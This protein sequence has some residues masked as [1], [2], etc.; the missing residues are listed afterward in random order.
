M[1]PRCFLR[2]PRSGLPNGCL[3]PP[4][5]LYT[6]GFTKKRYHFGCSERAEGESSKPGKK[7]G[8]KSIGAR[9]IIESDEENEDEDSDGELAEEGGLDGESSR[10]TSGRKRKTVDYGGLDQ[11][12]DVGIGDSSSESGGEAIDYSHP[13]ADEGATNSAMSGDDGAISIDDSEP[14]E[15]LAKKKPPAPKRMS[16]ESAAKG[17]SKASQ[18]AAPSKKVRVTKK[19]AADSDSEDNL[20]SEGDEGGSEGEEEEDADF[21]QETSTKKRQPKAT[22]KRAPARVP[23]A[24]K[25]V[26]KATPKSKPKAATAPKSKAKKAETAEVLSSDEEVSFSQA[27]APLSGGRRATSRRANSASK[28]SYLDK[29]SDEEE[30]EESG[31]AASE[32]E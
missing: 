20:S 10:R 7:A 22:P 8:A 18:K 28:V 29:G 30:S 9:R 4:P 26:K 12:S 3:N 14:D 23:A 13:G 5:T 15:P 16:A 11:G 24:K 27:A 1:R 21:G 32:S 6:F 17:Y 25:V 19:K 2:Y 31:D